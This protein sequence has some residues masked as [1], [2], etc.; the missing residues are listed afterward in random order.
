MKPRWTRRRV[1]RSFLRGW[2][3]AYAARKW[4]LTEERVADIV[5]DYQ[6][7]EKDRKWMLGLDK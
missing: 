1:W 6:P 4:R 5:R 2:S 7:D 3:F